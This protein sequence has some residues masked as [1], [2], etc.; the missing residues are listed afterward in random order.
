MLIGIVLGSAGVIV[1]LYVVHRLAGGAMA[2]W[3]RRFGFSELGDMASRPLLATL[4]SLVS[5]AATPIA[6]AW[7]RHVEHEA[8]RFGLELTQDNHAAAE[9]FVKL[10]EENLANP[11][12]GPFFVLWRASHPP[13]GERIEFANRY[14]PWAEGKPLRYGSY[15][16]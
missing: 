2:R 5:L 12:P 11:R 9:G 6:L 16:R 10:Q 8:D 14:R 4:F 7:S 1:C 15:F 13:I 3:R